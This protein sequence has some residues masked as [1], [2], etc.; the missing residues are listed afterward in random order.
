M[1]LY[2]TDTRRYLELEG[3]ELEWVFSSQII[4]KSAKMII[5]RGWLEGSKGK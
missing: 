5:L 3:P 4:W 1:T 2:M